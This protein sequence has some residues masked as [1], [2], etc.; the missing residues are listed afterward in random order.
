M[1]NTTKSVLW[2]FAG[3]VVSIFAAYVAFLIF[4][5]V[6]GPGLDIDNTGTPIQKIFGAAALPAL[7][8]VAIGGVL[9]R[10]GLH[11]LLSASDE[12]QFAKRTA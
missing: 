1:T 5:F 12:H 4:G 2:A 9:I 6:L 8:I 7:G 3:P 10:G 11:S